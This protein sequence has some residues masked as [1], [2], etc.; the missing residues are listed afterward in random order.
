MGVWV[1]RCYIVLVQLFGQINELLGWPNSLG[2]LIKKL[3]DRMPP[4]LRTQ[5]LV[6]P[7]TAFSAACCA[8]KQAHSKSLSARSCLACSRSR[9]AYVSQS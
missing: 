6:K 1:A 2:Q 4:G 9:L 5:F 3:A 8:A 7:F